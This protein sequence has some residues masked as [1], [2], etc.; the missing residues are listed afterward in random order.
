MHFSEEKRKSFPI[1]FAEIERFGC[2]IYFD[3]NQFNLSTEVSH[4]L[5]IIIKNKALVG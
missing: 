3:S 4:S 2:N 1:Q 5:L